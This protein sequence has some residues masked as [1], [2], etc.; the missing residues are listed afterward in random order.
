MKC[1]AMLVLGTV[2]ACCS[3]QVAFCQSVPPPDN[4]WQANGNALDS[5][6]GDNGT[7]V[8]S[9]SYAPGISTNDQAFAFA[10]GTVIIPDAANLDPTTNLTV[11]MWIKSASGVNP[12]QYI[13]AKTGAPAGA[14]YAFYTGGSGGLFFWVNVP[15]DTGYYGL[16]ISPGVAPGAIWDGNWHQ[17]TGVY[18]GVAVHL[19]VDGVEAGTGTPTTTSPPTNTIS[20]TPPGSLVLGAFNAGGADSWGGSMTEIKIFDRALAG[21]DVADTYTNANSPFATLGLASWWRANGNALDSWGANNGTVNSKSIGYFQGE[22][23]LAFVSAG[24][25]ILVSNAPTLNP[26]NITVQA[27]VKST[28]PGTYKYVLAK[29]RVPTYGSYAFYTGGNGGMTFYVAIGSPGNGTLTLSPAAN[30]GQ[31]WDG[32]WH[33]VT[34]T[35]DGSAVHLYVDG[36]EVGSGTPAPGTIDY[37]TTNILNNGA[38]VIA[39]DPTLGFAMAGGIDEVKIWDQ[40]LSSQQVLNSYA[41]SNLVSWWRAETNTLDS[42]GTNNGVAVGNVTYAPG[43]LTGTA[44]ELNNGLVVVTDSPSLEPSGNLTVE[45]M[46]SAAPPGANKYLISKS[47]SSSNASYAF[48][49]GT[50]GGLSFYVTINGNAVASPSVSPSVIWDGNYHFIA[51]TY[52]G[53]AVHFYLDGL[54]VGS[55]T[56][57][58]GTVQYGTSFNSGELLLGDFNNAPSANNFVGLLDEIQFYNS[59]LSLSDIQADAF[60]PALIISQPQNA[61]AL[62]GG[63]ASFEVTAL[64]SGVNYNWTFN[65]TNISGATSSVL[66]LTNI[67]TAQAGNYQ[68][69]VSTPVSYITNDVLGGLSFNL[70]GSLV[71]VPQNVSL[72]PDGSTNGMALQAW[73]RS[74]GPGA[75]K[76]IATQPLPGVASYALYTGGTGGAYFYV[77]LDGGN[78]ILSPG[79]NPSTL[80]DG[81]WHQLTGVYDG[82][83]VHLFVDGSEILPATDSVVGGS[84]DYTN[85]SDFIIGDFSSP[86]SGSLFGGDI[87]NVKLFSQAL[88][89]NNVMASYTNAMFGTA[90]TNGL[91]SWWQGNGN[92]FDSYGSNSGRIVPPGG[93]VVLSDVATLTVLLAP[94]RLIS[95]SVNG[96]NFQATL[97]GP[98]GQTNIIQSTI[99]LSS[100]VW[101][102]IATNVV[103]FTFTNPIGVNTQLFYRAVSQ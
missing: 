34:G 97:V 22:Q 85:A 46:V 38:L 59:A 70:V 89:T 61:T 96:G 1:L 48:Y 41:G 81:N 8:N 76:Y 93:G 43:R 4:W 54:E 55:G 6:G 62:T 27:W 36:I 82:E 44:F 66:T 92:P 80:W 33:Q 21:S 24:G 91:V 57:A 45:A 75:Y 30:P 39:N 35:Y 16:I 67:S 56:P 11:Q 26:L 20:Y 15:S 84:I 52:D 74:T 9:L 29:S 86:P 101:T 23:G 72:E 65:G 98:N 58:S 64:P 32:A 25:A 42:V 53:A 12:F 50:N 95:A 73:V 31:V 18:D 90:G 51:G 99:S 10:G 71:D 7:V 5:V 14:S 49:T 102:S 77:Y 13:L 87:G 2:T 17:V 100:P 63:T 3:I 19:Y 69:A 68:V 88:N 40:A 28:S 103:P 47:L 37:A 79:A 83:F 78:L 94:S 60:Q